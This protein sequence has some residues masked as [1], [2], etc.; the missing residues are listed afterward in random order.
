MATTSEISGARRAKTLKTVRRLGK[1]VVRRKRAS[2]AQRS[3]ARSSYELLGLKA[4]TT[5]D[6]VE[7]V[8]R[9]LNFNSVERLRQKMGIP[10]K[11]MA[12]QLQIKFR[13]L[14]RRKA[15]GRLH[16]DESDRVLRASRLF[17]H[18]VELFDGNEEAARRW[19]LAPQR[20]LGGAVPLEF[21]R[22][23]VGAREVE[24]IIGRLEHGVFT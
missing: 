8:E 5:L 24:R 13:T 18:A 14:L 7:H 17:S 23:E 10:M 11:A 16:P 19:L 9:G 15:E 4:E 20:A 2:Q 1:R 22:S 21:A 12:E 6:L 3:A